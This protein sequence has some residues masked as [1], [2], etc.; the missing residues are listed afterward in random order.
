MSHNDLKGL[1]PKSMQCLNEIGIFTKAD[2]EKMGAIKTFVK[3]KWECTSMKPSLNLLYSLV[4]ALEGVHWKEIAKTEKA[5]L[6]IELDA[7]EAWQTTLGE[8]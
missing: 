1:G 2:L 3:L 8:D 4:G 6:L 7:Y 5:R